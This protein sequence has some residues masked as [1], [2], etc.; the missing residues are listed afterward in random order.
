M[1][2][3]VICKQKL[4]NGNTFLTCNGERLKYS[5]NTTRLFLEA[6]VELL[7]FTVKKILLEENIIMGYIYVWL[8]IH[9]R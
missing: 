4:A 2:N 9:L 5:V 6:L 8:D 3:C 7:A 1:G